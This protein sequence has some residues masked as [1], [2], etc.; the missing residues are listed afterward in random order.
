MA[1]VWAWPVQQVTR[2]WFPSSQPVR[3]QLLVVVPQVLFCAF[4]SWHVVEKR[5]LRWKPRTPATGSTGR[6]AVRAFLKLPSLS[7]SRAIGRS[8]PRKGDAKVGS[9]DES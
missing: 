1:Y 7:G 3:L 2:L 9:T 4:V 5:A 8:A 6:P